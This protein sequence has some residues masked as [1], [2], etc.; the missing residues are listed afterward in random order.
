MR[1]R[2]GSRLAIKWHVAT[3][4][5]QIVPVQHSVI[6]TRAIYNSIALVNCLV[7]HS[8]HDLKYWCI[9]TTTCTSTATILVEV[10][11]CVCV[12]DLQQ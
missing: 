1:S 2:Q 7:R 8:I 6:M 3:Y 12:H 5:A 10:Q 9:T 11:R 4:Y